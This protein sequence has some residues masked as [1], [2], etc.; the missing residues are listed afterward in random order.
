MTIKQPIITIAGHVDHGKTSLADA[1]RNTNVQNTEAGGITQKIS[2]TKIPIEHLKKQCPLIEKNNIK[3]DIPGFLF[4]D[5][6]GHAA[7]S[8]LRKRGGSLADISILLIDINE[9]IKPQTQEVIELL[10]LNKIPFVIALNKIDNISGWR[11]QSE[12]LKE[13]IDKQSANVKMQFQEKLLTLMGSLHY[14]GFNAKPYYEITDFSKELALIPCSAK[15]REGISELILTLAGISEK[16]LKKNL[17][18]GKNTKGL[19]LE[20]KKEKDMQYAEC[21]LYDG[22][23]NS[24]DEIAIASFNEPIISKI[25]VL[26]EIENISPKFKPKESVS[27]ST[28]IRIQ[29]INKENVLAGMPFIIFKNNLDEIKKEFKKEIGNELKTDKKGIIIKSDSLGS[30]E[31]LFTLLKQNNFQIINYDI[32]D[33]NKKDIISAETNLKEDPINAVILG[34]NV[35]EDKEVK[36]L[37]YNIK[38]I[39]GEVIYKIIED[40]KKYQEEKTNELKKEKLTELANISKI[41]ILH[42]YL[43][44]HSNPAVFGVFIEAGKIKF[45]TPL[46]DNQ[47]NKIAKIKDIQENNKKVEEAEKGKEVAISLPGIIFDRVLKDIDYLY[48]DLTENQFKKFKENKELLSKDEIQTLQKIAEIKRKNN[49]TWGV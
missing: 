3:L 40:L 28:G 18:L 37:N 47:G 33:I 2:F 44:R 19:I 17:E 24:K 36:N 35:E 45:G 7:F 25:R 42:Q 34:F 23:L 1:I 16:F 14:Y 39:K 48:S 31:A 46:I 26:E 5:T 13:N 29:L 27:A 20:I 11:K 21:V 43:F 22:I 49:I 6:P 32:G 41:K 30:L 9:G 15:T 4:I 38:I 10:K 12:N 8:H